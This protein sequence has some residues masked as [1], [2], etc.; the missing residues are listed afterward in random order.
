[1]IDSRVASTNSCPVLFEPATLSWI[2]ENGAS[3]S[4]PPGLVIELLALPTLML[5][6]TSEMRPP[7]TVSVAGVFASPS[8]RLPPGCADL[9]EQ[10]VAGV[11]AG[12]QQ[13]R[14]IDQSHIPVAGRN[15]CAGSDL[16]L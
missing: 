12:Q 10:V 3:S 15:P 8:C 11:D 2:G 16:L 14:I 7:G 4:V 13:S 9:E 5:S 6:A 1:M